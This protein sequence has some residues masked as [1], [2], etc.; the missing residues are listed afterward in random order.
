MQSTGGAATLTTGGLNTSTTFSGNLVD[1]T[2]ML[3]LTKTGTGTLT[4]T[5]AGNT[6]TGATTVNAGAML[7]VGATGKITASASLSNSGTFQIDTGG[8]ANF[9]GGATNTATGTL[10]NNGTLSGGLNNMNIATNS[11]TINGR[12][13]ELGFV[14]DDGH[15]QWRDHQH[16]DSEGARHYDGAINNNAGSFIVTGALSNDTSFTNASGATLALGANTFTAPLVTNNGGGTITSTSG[17]IAGNLANAGSINMVNGNTTNSLSV[18]GTYTASGAASLNVDAQLSS[19]GAADELRLSGTGSGSTTI[20]ISNVG[21]K[22]YFSTPI[23]VVTGAGG[24][25]FNQGGGFGSA[26]IVNYSLQNLGGGTWG[27]VSTLNPGAAPAFATS[28]A[29]SLAAVN[30]GF[31]QKH[32][33]SSRRRRI[34]SPTNGAAV[35]GSVSPT[36]ATM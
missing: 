14:H 13:D 12:R 20:N 11:G 3:G 15:G 1:G 10:T 9:T 16:R 26:G 17:T 27:I 33:P 35:R 18:T 6:Y 25:S 4:L 8:S 32:R 19:G 2:G 22:G 30:V 34:P 29:A 31:F 28:I 5:G 36:A 23:P 24:A 21:S 7:E